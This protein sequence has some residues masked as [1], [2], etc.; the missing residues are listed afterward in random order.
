MVVVCSP[1][2]A[3]LVHPVTDEGAKS[4]TVYFPGQGQLW[5]DID[6]FEPFSG[7]QSID[8][9]VNLDKVFLQVSLLL[10]LVHFI[11]IQYFNEN[12]EISLGACVPEGRDNN[13]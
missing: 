9:P 5:Y 8:V 3:L 11:L 10:A 13:T 2:D 7:A 1:G 12:F 4:V 6:T